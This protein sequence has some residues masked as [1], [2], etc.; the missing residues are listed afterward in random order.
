MLM[1]KEICKGEV[2]ESRL[3]LHRYTTDHTRT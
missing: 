3:V 1:S 2:W